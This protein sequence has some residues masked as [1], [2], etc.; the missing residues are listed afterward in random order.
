M[1]RRES[2]E[3]SSDLVSLRKLLGF[4]WASTHSVALGLQR[5]NQVST[6]ARSLGY[7]VVYLH[8]TDALFRL[9]RQRM[10]GETAAARYWFTDTRYP[11]LLVGTASRSEMLALCLLASLGSPVEVDRRRDV[12]WD[13]PFTFTGSCWPLTFTGLLG[14]RRAGREATTY[15]TRQSKCESINRERPSEN[16]RGGIRSR[17]NKKEAQHRDDEVAKRSF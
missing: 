12:R 17:P 5:F 15:N 9:Q 14:R 7:R 4:V 3:Q 10:R 6:A 2:R 16:V 8:C 1:I 13:A 11:I